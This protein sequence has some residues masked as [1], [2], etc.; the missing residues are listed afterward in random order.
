MIN[1]KIK[2][3]RTNPL[4]AVGFPK[5]YDTTFDISMAIIICIAT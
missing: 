2:V 3:R 4:V 5:R 1:I